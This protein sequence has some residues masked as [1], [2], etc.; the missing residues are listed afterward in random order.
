MKIYTKWKPI[1]DRWIGF[2]KKLI[3]IVVVLNWLLQSCMLIE[4]FYNVTCAFIQADSLLFDQLLFFSCWTFA[5]LLISM[6][7]TIEIWL[8]FLLL[9]AFGALI[10]GRTQFICIH[11]KPARNQYL[12]YKS[13]KITRDRASYDSQLSNI[14]TNFLCRGFST[15]SGR[16]KS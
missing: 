7:H 11:L 10:S 9:F 15:K 5:P 6:Y 2:F 13:L 12:E 16:S 4:S 8:S 14:A 1:N 3:T